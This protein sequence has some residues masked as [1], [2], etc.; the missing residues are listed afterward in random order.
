M[1]ALMGSELPPRFP[2]LERGK[3]NI[4]WLMRALEGTTNHVSLTMVQLPGE[5]CSPRP[6]R[7]GD[8]RESRLVHTWD[9]VTL[10]LHN[11]SPEPPCRPSIKGSL[12]SVDGEGLNWGQDIREQHKIPSCGR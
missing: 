4:R 1:G 2:Y 11:Y 9:S 5:P 10:L 7:V 3:M 12:L 6:L 8:S